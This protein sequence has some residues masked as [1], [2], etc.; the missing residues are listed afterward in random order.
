[1]PKY[2]H[3]TIKERCFIHFSLHNNVPKADIARDL[4]RPRS[5]IY[6]EISRNQDASEYEASHADFLYRKRRKRGSSLSKQQDFISH[7]K[8]C[9]ID[10]K[11]SPEMIAGR[12]KEIDSDLGFSACLES[13]YKYIYE[14]KLGQYL[15]S[16]R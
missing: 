5:T 6:R 14:Y 4:G 1:M 16:K 2:Q 12:L 3:L 7:I 15:P 8:T 11:W 10:K 9:L 13:I